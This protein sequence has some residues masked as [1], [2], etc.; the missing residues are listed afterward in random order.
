M[1]SKIVKTFI[2]KRATGGA[3]VKTYARHCVSDQNESILW[4]VSYFLTKDFPVSNA[5]VIV[6]T[7]KDFNLIKVEYAI[8]FETLGKSIQ[9]LCQ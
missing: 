7:F 8:S 2:T 4:F 5:E 9:A 6:K 1:K 3:P